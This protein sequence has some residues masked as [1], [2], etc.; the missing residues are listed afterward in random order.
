ML[1]NR[2]KSIIFKA[3]FY[4]KLDLCLINLTILKLSVNIVN[5]TV[6]SI[7]YRLALCTAAQEVNAC[8]VELT[9]FALKCC[10]LESR[11]KI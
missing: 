3:C 5:T 9:I 7:F 6:F 10:T 1:C 8:K 11:M 4:I 2:Q